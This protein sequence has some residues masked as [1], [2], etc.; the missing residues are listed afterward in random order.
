MSKAIAAAMQ[1]FIAKYGTAAATAA[2]GTPIFKETILTAAGLES[3]Y[4]KSSLTV[5]HNNF[6]GIKADSRWKG[7]KAAY[8]TN[9]QRKDGSVYVVTAYFRSYAKPE[10]CF[11]DYVKFVQGPRY[12]AAGVTK[13]KTPQEQF[14][15]LQKAGY[16]TDVNYSTKL[17][18]I[19]N[20]VAS[21]ISTH[22]TAAT[23]GATVLLLLGT[24]FF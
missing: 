10:D 23:G 18:N 12:I 5:K 3:A 13:A 20:S 11:A 7:A 9:E 24:F 15:K 2:A 4:G 8:K 21:W 14:E 16:A 6:F 19:F 22:P 17:K 1:P